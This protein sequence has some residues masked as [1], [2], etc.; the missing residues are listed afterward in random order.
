MF[1]KGKPISLY[2][3]N[4]ISVKQVVSNLKKSDIESSIYHSLCNVLDCVSQLDLTLF[5]GNFQ[6]CILNLK[7]VEQ[8]PYL[9]TKQ[10]NNFL[11][12]SIYFFLFAVLTHLVCLNWTKIYHKFLINHLIVIAFSKDFFSK[13]YWIQK[14]YIILA[15]WNYCQSQNSYM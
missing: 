7:L 15:L 8:K 3:Y 6:S 14:S 12:H 13:L 5:C 2:G 4:I 11:C 9:T 10:C 1:Q